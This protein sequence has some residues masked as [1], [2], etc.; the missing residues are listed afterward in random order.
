MN[1]SEEI[2]IE[3]KIDSLLVGGSIICVLLGIFT[4][5][6]FLFLGFNKENGIA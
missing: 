3:Q 5:L 1:V 4:F 6:S 2:I